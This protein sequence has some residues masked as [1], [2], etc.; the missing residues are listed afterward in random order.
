[1]KFRKFLTTVLALI[2]CLTCGIQ[3][4]AM[5]TDSEII[6]AIE[7]ID[8]NDLSAQEELLTYYAE[9]YIKYS[10]FCDLVNNQNVVSYEEFVEAYECSG[11]QDV[12]EFLD[13]FLT[14]QNP[15][16]FEASLNQTEASR[17]GSSKWYFNT[18]ITLPQA[19]NYTSYNLLSR[20]QRGDILYE[21]TGNSASLAGHASIIEG[22]FWS[23]TKDQFYIRVIEAGDQGVRRGVFDEERL[24]N[25]SGVIVR[26]TSATWQQ[27]YDAVKFCID[28][29]GNDYDLHTP[30][31]SSSSNTEWYCSELV[32]AAYYNAGINLLNDASASI[33]TPKDL[34]LSSKTT[35][36]SY[37][38]EKPASLFT[39][40]SGNWAKAYIDLLVNAGMISGRSSSS[41]GPTYNMTRGDFVKLL[42]NLTG[43][44]PI[45]S[46]GTTFSDVTSGTQLY[47]AVKWASYNGIVNGYDDGTFQPDN[48]L[49]RQQLVAFL[50]RFATYINIATPYDN[51]ALSGF[52]DAGSVSSYAVI[53]MKWAITQSV[54]SGTTT[55][56]LSPTDPCNRAQSAAIASRFLYNCM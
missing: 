42:Y 16:Y 32:W 31:R 39:D 53:P 6:E 41:Y 30:K 49:T 45:V 23:G 40:T 47:Y 51:N 56:T 3:V 9:A 25:K 22:V 33:V 14:E 19:A 36:V 11:Q 7:Y 26:A 48:P 43:S 50:Y 20:V 13:S 28:H 52:S 18:G 8:N 24:A 54:I 46:G 55:T 10:T 29:L 38:T 34:F 35:T 12:Y 21:T 44:K 27:K 2:I 17:S 15:D 4:I 1:M 37:S 5:E